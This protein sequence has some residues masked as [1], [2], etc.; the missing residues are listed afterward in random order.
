MNIYCWTEW[1][2]NL[3]THASHRHEEELMPIRYIY[4]F[5]T[6]AL[7]NV[8]YHSSVN[9][10]WDS[11]NIL[12]C[13]NTFWRGHQIIITIV[14]LFEILIQVSKYWVS[15]IGLADYV[16]Q[17]IFPGGYRIREKCMH[18]ECSN[19]TIKWPPAPGDRSWAAHTLSWLDSNLTC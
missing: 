4:N 11:Q 2:R 9:A 13:L 5:R 7:R 8:S 6:I 1:N 19:L 12:Q 17:L 15:K 10:K 3:Q 14:A 18:P 16:L